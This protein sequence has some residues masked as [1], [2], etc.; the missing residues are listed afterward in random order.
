[1][2]DSE[3]EASVHQGW[4]VLCYVRLVKNTA[5]WADSTLFVWSRHTS[6]LSS[7]QTQSQLTG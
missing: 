6:A 2:T 1:M 7:K 3:K 5:A 4:L